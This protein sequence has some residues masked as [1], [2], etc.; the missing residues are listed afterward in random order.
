MA[1]SDARLRRLKPKAT[2][3]E[4]ADTG[5][6]FVEVMSSGPASRRFATGTG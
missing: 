5:G 2:R 3:D 4:V 6:L 1:L